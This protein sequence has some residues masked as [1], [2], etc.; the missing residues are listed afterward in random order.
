M[1]QGISASELVYQCQSN[2]LQKSVEKVAAHAKQLEELGK[3][4]EDSRE[5]IARLEGE[6]RDLIC[7]NSKCQK[8]LD[9]VGEELQIVTKEKQRLVSE[10]DDQAKEV[11][12]AKSR[13]YKPRFI[14]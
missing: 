14:G 5:E 6:V 1:Y 8:M 13:K 7:A 10:K 2:E 11:R 12:S 3:K 9:E 4:T